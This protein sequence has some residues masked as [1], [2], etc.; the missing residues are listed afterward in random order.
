MSLW[1]RGLCSGLVGFGLVDSGLK[2]PEGQAG[3]SILFAPW[4]LLLHVEIS[5]LFLPKN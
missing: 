4:W 5:Q 3:K 2:L 1:A